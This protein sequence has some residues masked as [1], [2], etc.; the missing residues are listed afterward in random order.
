MKNVENHEKAFKRLLFVK[1]LPIVGGRCV[2]PL[3]AS[4]KVIFFFIMEDGGVVGGGGGFDQVALSQSSQPKISR[5]T[6]NT[7]PP[8]TAPVD[9]S[10]CKPSSSGN[11]YSCPSTQERLR[12]VF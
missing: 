10:K 2:V 4:Q 1:T 11:K 6:L 7:S 12:L 5:E 8:P 9:W 3:H